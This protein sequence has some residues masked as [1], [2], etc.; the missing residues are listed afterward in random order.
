MI[1]SWLFV[2]A[3]SMAKV[4][5]AEGLGADAVILDLED[6]VAINAKEAARHAAADYLRKHSSAR[7]AQLWVRIN[8]LDGP[9]AFADLDAIVGARPDGIMLPKSNGAADVVTL[10]R[11][12][13]ALEAKGGI[14]AGA[15]KIL[16]ITSETAVSLFAFG[17]YGQ[18]RPPRLAS[19]TWGAED[20]PGA[21]GASMNRFPDGSFT[22]L[23]RMA[24][25]LCIAAAAAAEVPAI[26]TVYPA[27]RDLDGLRTFATQ[28]R[29]E[30]FTG[31]LA[32][33]PSQVPV[34]N[35][36]FTPTAE[37]IAHAR[38]IVEA[39]AANPSAGVLNLDGKMFDAPHLK[40]AQRLLQGVDRTG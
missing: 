25:T 33:H 20:M 10:S 27:F 6:A 32:I 28:S 31:M 40:L 2:P 8:P 5:K 29:R 16:P 26:E 19:L 11:Q 17:S 12:I 23:C 15:I 30:G 3:D 35:E 13:D 36:V 9:Y 38:R 21:V 4:A 14:A 34:I 7:F 22:D 18:N 37:E 39:F 1:R 24:R